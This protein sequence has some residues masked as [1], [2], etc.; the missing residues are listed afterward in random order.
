MGWKFSKEVTSLRNSGCWKYKPPFGGVGQILKLLG[1]INIFI[2][3][4]YF[5]V[6][7]LKIFFKKYIFYF[8]IFTSEKHFKK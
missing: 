4:Y 3:L 8:D 2:F 6:L 7:I 5:N 1:V